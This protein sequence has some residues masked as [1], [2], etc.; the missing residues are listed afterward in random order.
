MWL[1][2]FCY[3]CKLAITNLNLG[4]FVNEK[5]VADKTEDKEKTLGAGALL[6]A[7]AYPVSGAV[8]AYV[9]GKDI[10]D[11]SYETLREPMFS[12]QRADLMKKIE[13]LATNSDG[14]PNPNAKDEV[15]KMREQYDKSRTEFFK[16]RGWRDI[17]DHFKTLP[18]SKKN[19]MAID[20][21]TAA[22]VTLGALLLVANSKNV[23]NDLF[24]KG[25]DNGK[26]R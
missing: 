26:S 3:Y 8:G 15:V 2:G 24:G 10:Y 18:F 7:A 17:R 11:S 5:P 13:E 22:G 12:K 1:A 16:A 19:R 25:E 14:S 23:F 4:A 20:A 9:A 21:L 6:N